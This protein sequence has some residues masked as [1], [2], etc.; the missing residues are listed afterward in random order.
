MN[1]N[2]YNGQF[3]TLHSGA[4]SYSKPQVAVFE[5]VISFRLSH[6][7]P[8]AKPRNHR[9]GTR[10]E[11]PQNLRSTCLCQNHHPT[12]TMPSCLTLRAVVAALVLPQAVFSSIAPAVTLNDNVTYIGI[13]KGNVEQFRKIPHGEDTSG[14]RRFRPPEPFAAAPNTVFNAQAY[15]PSCPQP[16]SGVLPWTSNATDQSEDCLSLA[17]TRPIPEATNNSKLPVFAYVYGGMKAANI[18]HCWHYEH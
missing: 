10:R 8:N 18:L 4:I 13:T 15:G 1:T 9:K 17:I 7:F 16:V 14:A 3:Y 5:S 12:G 6:R 11:L 2:Y